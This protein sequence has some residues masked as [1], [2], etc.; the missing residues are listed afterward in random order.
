[1]SGILL[2]IMG[3][4]GLLILGSVVVVLILLL[5]Q[6]LRSLGQLS[7][8][9]STGT[10]G[11]R[12]KKRLLDPREPM[13]EQQSLLENGDIFNSRRAKHNKSLHKKQSSGRWW[14]PHNQRRRRKEKEQEE[15]IHL[16]QR[17]RAS[18][19][20]NVLERDSESFD[21]SLL[22]ATFC[23][24]SRVL[25]W[26]D[27]K[28]PIYFD[29]RVGK[30]SFLV[31]PVPHGRRGGDHIQSAVG[32]QKDMIGLQNTSQSNI[33]RNRNRNNTN[34]TNK[35]PALLLT[36]LQLPQDRTIKSIAHDSEPF[37]ALAD[38]A[39]SIRHPYLMKIIGFHA[40]SSYGR[41]SFG[42][43]VVAVVRGI[44]NAGSLRDVIFPNLHNPLS[45]A[46]RAGVPLS[47]YK[48]QMWSSQILQGMIALQRMSLTPVH[49]HSGN[50][51]VVYDRETEEEIIQ[52]TGF[53]YS[54]L[55]LDMSNIALSRRIKKGYG[56]GWSN[57]ETLLF[58]HLFFEM[59]FGMELDDVVP[60]YTGTNPTRRFYDHPIRR[61]LDLIFEGGG[62]LHPDEMKND[63]NENENENKIENEN[64]R[65][66][67][68]EKQGEV[69]ENK[70]DEENPSS[71]REEQTVNKEKEQAA[72]ETSKSHS[73][74]ELNSV[75]SLTSSTISNSS[76]SSSGPQWQTRKSKKRLD[77]KHLAEHWFFQNEID[78]D[79][80]D[81]LENGFSTVI[82]NKGP[83]I[84]H[85]RHLTWEENES[86]HDKVLK[87]AR[88]HHRRKWS[89]YVRK[90]KK[91][92]NDVMEEEKH[93]M[94]WSQTEP[95]PQ[96]T[97]RRR[98][99]TALS[100]RGGRGGSLSGGGGGSNGGGSNGGGGGSTASTASSISTADSSSSSTSIS[101]TTVIDKNE[102]SNGTAVS[103]GPEYNTFLRMQKAG[104]PEGAIRQN[105]MGAGIEPDPMFETIPSASTTSTTS[106]S[107]TTTTTTQKTAPRIVKAVQVVRVEPS[108]SKASNDKQGAPPRNQGARGGLLAAIRGGSKLKKVDEN[109]KKKVDEISGNAGG[110][111][112][113]MAAIMKRR[114][115]MNK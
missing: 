47:K 53:E 10:N 68:E 16:K 40:V 24:S 60:D 49:I 94:T 56:D 34:N 23:R 106:T 42:S 109:E 90:R 85:S 37:H 51:M 46:P 98:K 76:H 35:T 64:E 7:S 9:N 17:G 57:I 62:F 81:G 73:V 70:Q 4:V 110:G 74:T 27:R 104:V 105:M 20:L 63:V 22:A 115:S 107:T 45:E 92:N 3:A 48:L 97:D 86:R 89:R 29:H 65:N 111:N 75:N 93:L 1:M 13:N 43:Q 100:S 33:H 99:S 39:H 80:L 96:P 36:L 6:R 71:S 61:V 77:L 8:L 91:R 19:A 55:G 113:L 30:H 44:T 67:Q 84:Q 88:I 69:R 82:R 66:I 18:T 21:P 32:R 50:C 58:G 102:K 83:T 95:L 114:N 79:D 38:V 112:P 26:H 31:S 2:L 41:R 14:L 59:S 108:R 87:L 52:L 11:R 15:L 28:A 54:L 101:A 12:P 5:I 78:E 103:L 25:Q 72:G